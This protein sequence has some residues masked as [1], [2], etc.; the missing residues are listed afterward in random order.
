VRVSLIFA[1]IISFMLLFRRISVSRFTW[2]HDFEENQTKSVGPVLFSAE[3][4]ICR[5]ILTDGITDGRTDGRTHELIWG[6]L[7]NLRFLQVKRFE[8]SKLHTLLKKSFK[9]TFVIRKPST[10]WSTR[11]TAVSRGYAQFISIISLELVSATV[12]MRSQQRGD[13]QPE[14]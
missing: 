4:L 13:S 14:H 1:I 7:G 12:E 8:G 6:G 11:T 5:H 2:I 9:K 10:C 3:Y